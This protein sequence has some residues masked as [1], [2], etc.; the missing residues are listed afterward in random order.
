MKEI[1]LLHL[2]IEYKYSTLCAE[3]DCFRFAANAVWAKL[4]V[5]Y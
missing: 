5:I 1:I 2:S 4:T 3:Q